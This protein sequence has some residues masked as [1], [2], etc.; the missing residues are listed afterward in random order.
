MVCHIHRLPPQK[1]AL[2][3]SNAY[4]RLCLAGQAVA[5]PRQD[6]TGAQEWRLDGLIEA[7]LCSQFVKHK[8]NKRWPD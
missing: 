5:R 6:G 3:M 7:K 2:I 1:T 8:Q 4:A